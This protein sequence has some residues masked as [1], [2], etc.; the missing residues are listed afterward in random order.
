MVMKKI[1]FAAIATMAMVSVS[2]VFAS[3]RMMSEMQ[4]VSADTIVTGTTENSDANTQSN[5]SIPLD[6]NS[7]PQDSSEI[8][9]PS[10]ENVF[11]D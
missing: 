7:A 11:M 8:Q 1:F 5:D 2:N 4:V 6:D 3:N 10:A 9:H